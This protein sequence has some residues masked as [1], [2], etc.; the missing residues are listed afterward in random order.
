MQQF[1]P[2][3]LQRLLG[4]SAWKL[5]PATLATYI[6]K[7]SWIP[8]RH[9]TYIS[10]I[11]TSEMAKGN[12]RIIISLPPRHGKSEFNSV[13]T[14]TW[15]LENTP[16][17]E[18]IL[19][20]YGADLAEDFGRKVRDNFMNPDNHELSTVIRSDASQVSRFLTEHG[21]GMRSVGIGGPIY[22][23][24]ADVF[25]VDDYYK[26]PEEA[27]SDAKRDAVFD[28]FIAIAMS[29]LHPGGS[30]FIVATRWGTDDLA[31]RL[32]AMPDSPWKEIKIPAISYEPNEFPYEGYVDPLGRQP[33]QALWPERYS[34]EHLQQIK[35]LSGSYFWASIYQQKPLK[36]RGNAFQESWV[37]YVTRDQLPHYSNLRWVRSWD[38]AA[39]QDAGDWTVGT[40]VAR[41]IRNRNVYI[42]DVKRRQL[43]AG[44]VEELVKET[45]RTDGLGCQ[46]CIEQEP[47]SSGKALIEHYQRVV[48]PGYSVTAVRPTGDKFVRAQGYLAAFEAGEIFLVRDIWNTAF[49]DEHL[50]FPS[51][52][53]KEHD[54]Q[55]D[56][57]SQAY[58]HIFGKKSTAGAW[59]RTQSGLWVPNGREE[60]PPAHVIASQGGSRMVTGAVWGR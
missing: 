45:A 11:I 36:S 22:G 2:A 26:N 9:L 54:D 50:Q 12:A 20:S 37:R 13:W 57:T 6:S 10:S 58:N 21:G 28:W 30:V 32:L 24:G 16:Y 56:A 4:N 1:N 55:V 23:R 38:L 51:D 48:L 52:D 42:V 34:L 33:G 7:G 3:V 40:L 35:K 17:K 15:V 59:G 60:L 46:I 25:I 47:G 44:K 31:A 43:S 49:I 14:P 5:S 8:A 29:R 27:F 41:D 53:S 18:I 39:T 19:T